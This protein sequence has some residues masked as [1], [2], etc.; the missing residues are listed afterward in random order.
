MRLTVAAQRTL[1]L[2]V[3]TLLCT[4]P[5]IGR[6]DPAPETRL[7]V[8]LGAAHMQVHDDIVRG[9]RWSGP[10]IA[11]AVGAVHDGGRDLHVGGLR[12]PLAFLENRYGH[13]GLSW[14]L[15]VDY[16]YARKLATLP[17]GVTV[18]LGARVRWDWALQYYEDFDEEHLYWM[19]AYE[20]GPMLALGYEP[21]PA[22]RFGLAFDTSALALVSRPPRRRYYKIDRLTHV[23]FFFEKTH[24]S[25]RVTSLHAHVPLHL[26]LWY[27]LRLGPAARLQAG[28]SGDFVYEREPATFLLLLYT[29]TVGYAHAI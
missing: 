6:A 7:G 19:N 9:L 29:L 20:L 27:A 2:G 8:A 10:G 28:L 1:A 13:G 5:C 21:K 18:A 22:H 25:M 17:N 23:D 24:E 4:A 26:Q 3:V 15:H 11:F 12:F 14:D 16:G